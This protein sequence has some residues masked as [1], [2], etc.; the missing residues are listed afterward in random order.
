[1][2]SLQSL[3]WNGGIEWWNYKFSKK[4]AKRSHLLMH[5]D[6]NS[7]LM[8]CLAYSFTEVKVSKLC[9]DIIASSDAFL[10]IDNIYVIAY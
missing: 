10:C 8:A 9:I 5:E 3:D 4:E 2:G 7:D 1:M 6:N